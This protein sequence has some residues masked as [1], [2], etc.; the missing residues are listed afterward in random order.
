[1]KVE[2]ADC[3]FDKD[4]AARLLREKGWSQHALSKRSGIDFGSIHRALS[5]RGD[6]SLRNLVLMSK[7]LGVSPCALI[8]YDIKEHAPP[9]PDSAPTDFSC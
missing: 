7:A 5:G 8:R 9:G 6:P 3:T 4:F 2:K 1:M